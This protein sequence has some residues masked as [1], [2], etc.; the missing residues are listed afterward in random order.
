METGKESRTFKTLSQN[1]FT[2]RKTMHLVSSPP[3]PSFCLLIPIFGLTSSR[4]GMFQLPGPF[5]NWDGMEA[6]G[7]PPADQCLASQR[8]S[9]P[10]A[11]WKWLA[12]SCGKGSSPNV[13]HTG[14]HEVQQGRD[15]SLGLST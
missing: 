5:Q 1:I 15:K 11:L 14:K 13:P 3:P 6:W 4:T 2:E 12:I 9:L 10:Q 8:E 7:K